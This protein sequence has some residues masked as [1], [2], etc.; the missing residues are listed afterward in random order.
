MG[1]GGNLLDR[2]ATAL[3]C[4]TDTELSEALGVA[5]TTLSS[6]RSR[7]TIPIE[8]LCEVSK[9][10][11]I[12]LNWLLLGKGSTTLEPDE[13]PAVDAELNAIGE[14]LDQMPGRIT[15]DLAESDMGLQLMKR[16]LERIATA[17]VSTD[18]QKGIANVMLKFV[19]GDGAA[20]DRF[21]SHL[22]SIR[23]RVE[24]A[25]RD[26]Q[27][28]IDAVGYEPPHLI[29]LALDTVM[30]GHGLTKEGAAILLKYL[31]AQA[32]LDH[33]EKSNKPKDDEP[34]GL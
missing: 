30:F 16:T 33:A 1:K 13:N 6:W 5:R 34:L 12:S 28:V 9:A 7:G 22:T 20:S 14:I 25:R 29:K 27:E 3:N 21:D 11:N 26:C 10:K 31:K 2:L 23:E 19:F 24:A 32:A 4:K 18:R 15:H 17:P 8:K